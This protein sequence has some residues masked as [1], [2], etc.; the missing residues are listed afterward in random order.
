MAIEFPLK[1]EPENA[2]KPLY[3]TAGG[4]VGTVGGG[5]G[6]GGGALRPRNKEEEAGGSEGRGR[7]RGEGG[8]YPGGFP[9]QQ[10]RDSA[11]KRAKKEE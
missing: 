9:W 10:F 8:R 7:K 11:K 4:G 2:V 3:G 1:I 5:E 6:G